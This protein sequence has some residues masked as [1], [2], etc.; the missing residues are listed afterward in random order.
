MGS[1][2]SV[3][4]KKRERYLYLISIH[5]LHQWI[6][7]LK[8]Y[9]DIANVFL[10]IPLHVILRKFSPQ[11]DQ[12]DCPQK[13][14]GYIS[15]ININIS[16]TY[17]TPVIF[18][19]VL[20]LLLPRSGQIIYQI[21]YLLTSSALTNLNLKHEQELLWSLLSNPNLRSVHMNFTRQCALRHIYTIH[22][23]SAPCVQIWA[24]LK[25]L[26]SQ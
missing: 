14:V 1:C 25:S 20:L 6:F 13:S 2:M 10:K 24:V 15:S 22:S 26:S 17:E 11:E 4:A 21:L 9:L 23:I 5:S 3:C 18:Q 16:T 8:K 7:K 19:Q 12:S